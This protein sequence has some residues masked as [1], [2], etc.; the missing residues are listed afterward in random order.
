VAQDRWYLRQYEP[1]FP[2]VKKSR[3]FTAKQLLEELLE[4]D[5]YRELWNSTSVV[6]VRYGHDFVLRKHLRCDPETGH[7]SIL[8]RWATVARADHAR[9]LSD[10]AIHLRISLD[11]NPLTR[12]TT[13]SGIPPGQLAARSANGMRTCLHCGL[14]LCELTIRGVKTTTGRRD[15]H[16]LHGALPPSACTGAIGNRPHGAPDDMISWQEEGTVTATPLKRNLR[17][18]PSSPHLL[19]FGLMTLPGVQGV[20]VQWAVAD[21]GSRGFGDLECW[22]T[23]LTIAVVVTATWWYWDSSSEDPSSKD[24][25]LNAAP[26]PPT[27]EHVQIGTNFMGVGPGLAEAVEIGPELA[28]EELAEES[29]HPRWSSKLPVATSVQETGPV[30]LAQAAFQSAPTTITEY[31]YVEGP[32]STEEL[33]RGLEPKRTGNGAA[34]RSR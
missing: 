33:L 24:A 32:A 1:R 17:N 14:K 2:S 30:V 5:Q 26:R 34:K 20:S 13:D 22:V 10:E 19:K 25:A 31:V 11:N 16:P 6:C 23:V 21:L 15:A 18:V 7:I 3:Q 4:G 12:L 28:E 8:S 29:P 27:P 9:L